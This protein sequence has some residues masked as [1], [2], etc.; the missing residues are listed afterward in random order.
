MS[1]NSDLEE[2]HLPAENVDVY[3]P[4]ESIISHKDQTADLR[5]EDLFKDCEDCGPKVHDGVAKR[6]DN[7]CTKNLAKDGSQRFKLNTFVPRT[8]N[9]YLKV[10]RVKPRAMGRPFGQSSKS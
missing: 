9:K 10:P 2:D 1:K 7:A 4:A 5:Y 8:V 3:D 6:I